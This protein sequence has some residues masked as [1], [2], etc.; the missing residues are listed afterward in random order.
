[1]TSSVYPDLLEVPSPPSEFKWMQLDVHT[2]ELS[3][4]RPEAAASR[5]KWVEPAQ[6]VNSSPCLSSR[7]KASVTEDGPHE[8]VR[9]FQLSRFSDFNSCHERWVET[10]LLSV[11]RSL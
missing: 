10:Y 7:F 6:K 9:A 5:N 11:C 8:C 2:A 4:A 1:M 3:A